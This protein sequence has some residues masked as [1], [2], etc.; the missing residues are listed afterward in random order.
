MSVSEGL[1]LYFFSAQLSEIICPL[2]DFI[3]SSGAELEVVG[4]HEC[5]V[6]RVITASGKMPTFDAL[7]ILCSELFTAILVHV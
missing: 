1:P 3:V 6:R 7:K 4:F 2:S 5:V